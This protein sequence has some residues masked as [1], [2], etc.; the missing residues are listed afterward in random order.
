MQKL[1]SRL[2]S[3]FQGGLMVDIQNPDF[4]TR[5]AILRAKCQE[6]GDVV[7]ESILTLIAASLESNARELE[8]K[9]IQIIQSCKLL[10][11]PVNEESVRRFLGAP[12]PTTTRSDYKKIISSVNQYFNIKMIDLTGP[13]RKKELVFPRQLVMYLLY[14]DCQLPYER[15]GDILGG[16]DHTTIMHGVDKIKQTITRDREVQRILIELKQAISS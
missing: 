12:Q 3:R 13:A 9:L 6:R 8:G 15:I 10:N 16:R 1:E 4:D 7:D 11:Q 2:L 14:E 5:V